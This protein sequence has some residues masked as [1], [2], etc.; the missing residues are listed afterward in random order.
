MFKSNLK[1]TGKLNIKKY[2]E[3]SNL[4]YETDVKNLV[5]TA[6]KEYVARR[7]IGSE[8]PLVAAGAFV[9][10]YRY[11]IISLGTTNWVNIGAIATAIVTG[12][13]SN[14][15]GSA[16]TILNV[17]AVTSGT[18]AVGTYIS[19]TGV[20]AGTYITALGTGSGGIGTY[21]VSSSQNVT[22]TTITGQPTI[23]TIFTASGDGS[24]TG[25]ATKSNAIG[26]MAIGD[27][28]S[29]S[30]VA[31]TSLVTETARVALETVSTNGTNASFS[32]VFPAGTGTGNV[33]EA[34]LFNYPEDRVIVFNGDAAVN[35]ADNKITKEG[36][37]LLSGDK[38]T[39]NDGGGVALRTG[40]IA[41]VT[42]GISNGS[43]SAGTILNVSAVTNG[44][45]VAGASVVGTGVEAG[46][47]IVEQI[48]GTTGGVGTYTVSTSQLA[49][50]TSI[51]TTR[52]TGNLT[53]GG[54]Y[55]IIRDSIDTI[56]LASTYTNAIAGSPTAISILSGTGSEHQ[57]VY[58]DM[59]CRTTFPVISKSPSETVAI[60]W[61]VTVG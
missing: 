30:A 15:S 33:I 43:G 13:I 4:V 47:L 54:T 34:G 7:L 52:V 51:V 24:G 38:V 36:H 56:K 32:A 17:S 59:L 9:E 12:I 23:G 14:G 20:T 40:T 46:T 45:I 42:G 57:L 16:G 2:D 58:G 19:G 37:G 53:D 3:A 25:L 28:P 1:L 11:T 61:T 49:A 29:S 26:F 21:T 6:G 18:L 27:D 44:T 60:S 55:Y 8:E 22:S 50:S 31:Q 48:G 10:G 39:Y 5:V 41:N 35:N